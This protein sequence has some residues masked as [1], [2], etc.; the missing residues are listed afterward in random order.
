MTPETANRID[1]R[2]VLVTGASRGI[3]RATADWLKAM[4]GEVF[5]TATSESGARG[6][7]ERLG[8]GRGLVLDVTDPDA[9]IETVATI[10]ERAG[11]VTVLVN[12][13]AIT[14]DQLLMRLKD[15]DWDAV[16]DTNLRGVMR[17]T[18][19]CLRG[20]LKEKFG[21]I[22]SVSSVVGYSGNPG[23]SNYAAAKAGVAGFSRSIAHELGSRGITAN[24][25]APGFIETDMTA[26]LDDKQRERLTDSIPLNRL[27]SVD[28]VAAA[29]GFLAA[30]ASGYVTGQTLHVNGGMYMT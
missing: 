2:V 25:V 1:G 14:R 5:G 4:G 21:R 27:G 10:K 20:M 22:I 13:A 11:A 19:A 15:D 26:E 6:I 12:N 30:D 24:V 23:Q 7:S 16:L 9:I 8:E 17:M 18:R 28:D 3:G 29:V